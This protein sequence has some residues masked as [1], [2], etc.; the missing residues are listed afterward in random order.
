[1]EAVREGKHNPLFIKAMK[2]GKLMS[3]SSHKRMTELQNEKMQDLLSRSGW[4]NG[5]SFCMVGV[6]LNLSLLG[7]VSTFQVSDP[8]SEWI[9]HCFQ[10]RAG[11]NVRCK[12]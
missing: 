10:R 12:T 6:R 11:N 8:S 5:P 7:L 3:E 1:M 9:V 4:A 2:C